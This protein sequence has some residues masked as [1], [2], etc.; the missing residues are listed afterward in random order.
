M[1]PIIKFNNGSPVVICNKCR[2]IIMNVPKDFKEDD[3][4]L[5]FCDKCKNTCNG[6]I[7]M[8]VL[9]DDTTKHILEM[10]LNFQEE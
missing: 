2:T 8:I 5:F 1:K 7:K 3:H 4:L 10:T 6:K 9:P